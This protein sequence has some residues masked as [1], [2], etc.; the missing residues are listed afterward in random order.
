MPDERVIGR[1]AEKIEGGRQSFFFRHSPAFQY[2]LV[3]SF[4]P[5]PPRQW[6]SA[7]QLL[8]SVIS[9]L[10]N[11]HSL[12]SIL[13]FSALH[14]IISAYVLPFAVPFILSL[15]CKSTQQGISTISTF[16]ILHIFGGKLHSTPSPKLLW[17]EQTRHGDP[18]P[19]R[20]KGKRTSQN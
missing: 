19:E 9:A 5:T 15:I 10:F 20:Q 16:E 12:S 8:S 13:V 6:P 17:N 2:S 1:E 4:S 14:A 3:P 11:P 7:L 18:G